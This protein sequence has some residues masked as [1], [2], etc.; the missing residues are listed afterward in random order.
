MTEI[1]SKGLACIWASCA[2]F[3]NLE[4]INFLDVIS[5]GS[6]FSSRM[7]KIAYRDPQL[8]FWALWALFS[9]YTNHIF[10]D[11]PYSKGTIYFSSVF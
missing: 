6:G 8:V 11:F 5:L 4:K 10:W 9:N 1:C 7:I 3:P 2:L